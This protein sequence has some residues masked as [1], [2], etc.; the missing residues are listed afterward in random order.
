MR[1]TG[2]TTATNQEKT[3][4][5]KKTSQEETKETKKKKQNR[6]AS[7]TQARWRSRGGGRADGR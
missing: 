5:I 3:K 2:Q 6:P 7:E 4:E 1:S